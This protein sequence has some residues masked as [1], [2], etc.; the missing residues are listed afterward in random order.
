[1]V[2]IGI[3]EPSNKRLGG[4]VQFL[5]LFFFFSFCK[6]AQLTS[7]F[8]NASMGGFAMVIKVTN[9]TLF[10]WSNIHM[11]CQKPCGT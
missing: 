3:R 9:Q 1:M 8:I 10:D 2:P 4:L 5:F 7:V 11:T 6:D